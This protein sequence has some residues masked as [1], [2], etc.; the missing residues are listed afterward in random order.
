MRAWSALAIEARRAETRSG[1]VHESAARACA[2]NARSDILDRDPVGA[3]V[4]ES[5]GEAR[6]APA[7]A[8][9]SPD[10]EHAR[11]VTPLEGVHYK[12]SKQPMKKPAER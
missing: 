8:S 3:C 2:G 9:D 4:H 6:S 5:E 12:P 11:R 10:Q 7:P 1:S